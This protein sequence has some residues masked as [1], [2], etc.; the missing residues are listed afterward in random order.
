MET[1]EINKM[2][3]AIQKDLT[4][5]SASTRSAHKRLDEQQKLITS[6]HDLAASVQV[7][8]AEMAHIKCDVKDTRAQIDALEGHVTD[9]QQ[10]PAKRWDN[11]VSHIITLI[12]GAVVAYVFQVLSTK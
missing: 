6:V 5:I 9:I 1:N 7:M 3:M 10:K 8:A 4:E 12:I 2:L 11:A